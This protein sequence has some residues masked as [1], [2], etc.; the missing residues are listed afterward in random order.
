MPFRPS[1]ALVTGASSGLGELIARRFAQRG[2]DLVLVAR[3]EDRLQALAEELAAAGRQV[4][5]LARD[6]AVP[7]AGPALA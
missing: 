3:R 4:H 7:A 2:A 1:L 6:I 5:V